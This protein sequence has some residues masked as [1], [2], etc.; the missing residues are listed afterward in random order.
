MN[1]RSDKNASR[2]PRH[3]E[4]MVSHLL[5]YLGAPPGDL[6]IAAV[7][8]S[9]QQDEPSPEFAER[10][11]D[12]AAA[13]FSL[14]QMAAKRDRVGFLPL[15]LDEYLIRLA[16]AARV[17]LSTLWR[18]LGIERPRDVLSV[19]ADR[20]A[21]LGSALGVPVHEMI[22]HLRLALLRESLVIPE[23]WASAAREG[24]QRSGSLLERCQNALEAEI[25][26]ADATTARRYAV[27]EHD[28]LRAY[29]RL[30]E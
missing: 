28:L 27:V 14:R 5:R 29:A 16:S 8:S 26:D 30:D 18:N 21:D 25:A 2:H 15:P 17:A 23:A 4:D 13:V 6:L 10:V 12:A 19:S 9:A 24:K 11:R 7:S 20:L 1:T 3:E 22:A